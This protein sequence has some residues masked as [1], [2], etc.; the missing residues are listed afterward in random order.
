[1]NKRSYS[2]DPY[3]RLKEKY[4]V[5]I[6]SGCWE[7]LA[8]SYYNGY[9]HIKFKNKTYKA[10]R[11][12]Y[13]LHNGPISDDLCVLH[14]CDNRKCI[15]PE[16]L[17]LGS[18]DDNMKDMVSKNR[19]AKGIFNGTSK[20]SEQDVIEIKNYLNT[21][22]YKGLIT[23]LSKKY[24]VSRAVIYSIKTGKTWSHVEVD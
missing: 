15:N 9:A 13:E 18:R 23:D 12:S 2:L 3:Q 16:H 6:D 21:N 24:D 14:K 17:F 4:K 22:L 11:F 7:Y 5:N 10:H 1:M 8:N 19:Q 20:L